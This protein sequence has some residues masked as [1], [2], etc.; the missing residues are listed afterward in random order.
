MNPTHLTL[1]HAVLALTLPIALVGVVNRT[2][3]WWAGR[4][5]PRL[6]QSAH[7]LRRLLGKR[8]VVSTVASPLFRVGPYVVLV[9]SLLAMS[10]VPLLGSFAPLQFSHD[11]VALAYTLGLARIALMVSAM[12]VGSSFEGMGAAREASFSTLAEP[13]LFLLIGS[14]GAATGMSSFA[15]L[16]G[17]LHTTPHYLWMVLP[18]VVALLILLQLEAARVP[19]DDPLT[20]LE[21][22]MIHEVMVLDHSGPDLAAMQYAAALKMTLY[23]GL[24]AALLNP[25]NPLTEPAL[26]IA[27]AVLLML[28]VAVVVG[29]FE[30]LMARL[31]MRAVPRYALLASGAALLSMLA[32]GLGGLQP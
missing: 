19:V 30:S 27:V 3:S 8:P 28:A 13:A 16:M 14:V 26:A 10:M 31:P 20:H 24:I 22:T 29:C 7:D 2:K 4:K 18:L 1:V 5:G 25:F 12:D 15:D 23:A 21:L 9:C 32:V 6:L 17:H 11:F